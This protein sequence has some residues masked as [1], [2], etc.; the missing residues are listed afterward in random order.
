MKKLVSPK[1][2]KTEKI[3]LQI[4][5]STEDQV[6]LNLSITPTEGQ[7]Y[8]ASGTSAIEVHN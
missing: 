1:P 4:D 8:K 3:E 6:G 2:N 7:H 5:H